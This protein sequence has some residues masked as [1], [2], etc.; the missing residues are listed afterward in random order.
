[1][2]KLI[3]LLKGHGI[4]SLEAPPHRYEEKLSL[5]GPALSSV[6]NGA[7]GL[8]HTELQSPSSARYNKQMYIKST[9]SIFFDSYIDAY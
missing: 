5:P 4:S 3:L 7:V 8:K 9:H 6:L 2:A 1:M